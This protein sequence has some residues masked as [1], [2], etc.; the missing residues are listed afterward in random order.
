MT[1]LPYQHLYCCIRITRTHSLRTSEP[2]WVDTEYSLHTQQAQAKEKLARHRGTGRVEA[3]AVD[4][5]LGPLELWYKEGIPPCSPD[6][7]Q[8]DPGPVAIYGASP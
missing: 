1:D 7:L 8:P 5:D 2:D 3:W 4:E 6:E